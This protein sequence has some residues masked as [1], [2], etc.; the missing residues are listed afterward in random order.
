M[1]RA[2][3]TLATA[4]A[5]LLTGV[6]QADDYS[7][8][9]YAQHD[10]DNLTRGRG[11]QI[12]EVTTPAYA[13]DFVA[14]AADSSGRHLGKQLSEL[15]QGRLY[16]GL[17]GYVPTYGGTGDPEL[18]FAMNPRRVYFVSRTGAKLQGH[19]W[20]ASGT[21][22]KPGV[23]ITPGSIQGSDQM[24]WW[25]AI[26]LAQAGYVVLTFDA[27]G[28]G[29]SE[30]FGHEAGDLFPTPEGV[31]FQQ[32]QNFVDG[33]VDA[34]RFFL[35]S[36]RR[37]YSPA[38]WTPAQ[39]K[40]A[41]AA[42]AGERIDWS[43][44]G[45]VNVDPTQIGI[46]GHSLGARAVS[47]VQQCSSRG[48]AWRK[49]A[50]CGGR[51]YPIK[52]V[53]GWDT[54]SSSGIT[55]V[56]PGLDLEADGYFLSPTPSPTAPDPTDALEAFTAWRKAGL[57]SLVTVIRAGTHLDFSHV[58]FHGPSTRYGQDLSAYYTVA[59]MNRYVARSAALQRKGYAA[60]VGGPK[61]KPDLPWSANH[62][63]AR[64]LSAMTVHAPGG[65]AVVSA[66]DLRAYAGRSKVGDWAGA[67]ADTV[68]A[69]PQR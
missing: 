55:P 49:V 35:S 13:S 5:V 7:N 1:R 62:F 33:S 61:A 39:V 69:E 43:N 48:Q 46:A 41:R 53:V 30:T 9:D 52:A 47:V 2:A 10:A 32:E 15:R 40:A 45:F 68:G 29:Q 38:G 36:P 56:V 66:K 21:A 63:S 23:V 57:D 44:P 11:A 50:A 42:G 24:Y 64:R 6:A 58:P 14:A 20:G 8:P 60:L 26:A 34:L 4:L 25:A 18:Y 37:P 22:K 51:S 3:L 65:R 27:Q 12:Y 19:V 54:L 31:P 28:Q 16:G 59:W 67:N 17:S